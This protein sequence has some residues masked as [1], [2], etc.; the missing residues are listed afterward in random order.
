MFEKFFG[1]F[2]L[3]QTATATDPAAQQAVG[4][5]QLREMLCAALREKYPMPNSDMAVWIVEVYDDG[6]CIFQD[7]NG[8]YYQVNYSVAENAVTLSGDLV[9]VKRDVQYV[10]QQATGQLVQ[11]LDKEGWQ[12]EVVIIKAGKS[13]TGD[14]FPVELLQAHA[15][16]FEG[17]AAFALSEGQ[18]V[19][20]S[21]AKPVRDIIGTYDNV[22]MVGDEMRA[23]LTLL[24]T[25][26]WL[27]LMLI[28]LARQGKLGLLGISVDL[29]GSNKVKEVAGE[30]VRY[31]TKFSKLNGGGDIVWDPAA[32]GKFVRALAAGG[33][34]HS[35]KEEQIM[36]REQMLKLLQTRRPDLYAKID[37]ATVTDADLIKLVEEAVQ[38]VAPAPGAQ[39]TQPVQTQQT[40]ALTPEQADRILKA[41]ARLRLV[42]AV[43][44]SKLPE[45]AQKKLIKR[46]EGTLFNDADLQQAI[47][48]Y[49]ELLGQATESGRVVGFGDELRIDVE[50]EPERVQMSAAKLIFA[51][52]RQADIPEDIRNSDA[53][54]FTGL[55]QMYVYLTGDDR[56]TGRMGPKARLRQTIDSTT[57]PGLMENVIGRRLIAAYREVNYGE[58]RICSVGQAADFKTHEAIRMGYFGDIPTINPELQDYPELTKPSDEKVSFSVVQKGCMITITRKAIINDDLRGFQRIPTLGGRAARRTLARFVWNFFIN[59]ATYDVDSVAWFHANHGNLKSQALAALE[60]ADAITKLMDQT[61]PGSGEKLG[62]E[63]ANLGLL[64]VVPTALWQTAKNENERQYLDAGFT[65]N[66]VRGFFGENNENILVNPLLTDAND[67]G[68]F[69]DSRDIESMVL[70]FLMGQ[71]EPEILLADAPGVGEMF[72]ADKIQLKIRHE[73]EADI[74]DTRG[75]VK[76]VVAGG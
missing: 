60:I 76:S 4:H 3:K 34:E 48:D 12:W 20:E 70:N 56:I 29:F 42:A 24:Q 47:T 53:H 63:L 1:R 64:L 2:R 27:R 68:V 37:P 71:E 22:R 45:F 55:R 30:K 65:P 19:E 11:S 52:C 41:D 73:Y 31:W 16:M 28:D 15:P 66:P 5:E 58:R 39:G 33:T 46:F 9:P 40:G 74:L 75:A 72:R 17:T 57:F 13:L 6:R 62:M 8:E 69:R 44:D 21:M 7:M 51:N 32:G 61:E 43:A 36:N 54:P 59:N 38:Q 10:A 67:W 18:H 50:G 35:H 49:R 23:R 25:A 14:Y 26:D